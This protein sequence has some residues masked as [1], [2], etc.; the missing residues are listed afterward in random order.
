MIQMVVFSDASTEAV[1][2]ANIQLLL[3]SSFGEGGFWR[4]QILKVKVVY[5][6]SRMSDDTPRLL[7]QVTKSWRERVVSL[8]YPSAVIAIVSDIPKPFAS[9]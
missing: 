3:R 5:I 7:L 2:S 8:S 9:T 6:L 1:I 4:E